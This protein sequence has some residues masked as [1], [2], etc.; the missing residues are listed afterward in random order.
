MRWSRKWQR[1]IR[2]FALFP[3]RVQDEY[4]WLEVVY[5]RQKKKLSC[6][7]LIEHE[8]YNCDFVDRGYYMT[9]RKQNAEAR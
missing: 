8:W 5:I 3:I 6:K 4:R 2:R 1:V 9:W 7:P